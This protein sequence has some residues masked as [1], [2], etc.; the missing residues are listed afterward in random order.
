MHFPALKAQSEKRRMP[1]LV[2]AFGGIIFAAVST[3][4]APLRTS[5]LQQ[6]G[7]PL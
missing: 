2:L 7:C 1:F 4:V 3:L 6:R 5:M